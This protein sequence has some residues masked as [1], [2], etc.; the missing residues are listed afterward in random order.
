[1]IGPS[2]LKVRHTVLERRLDL[3]DEDAPFVP[4]WDADYD[5][6]GDLLELLAACVANDQPVLL[7][8]PTGCG[9]STAIRNLAA[10][11][12]QPMI[13]ATMNGQ[14]RESHLF[15]KH[16]AAPDPDSGEAVTLWRDG[17]VPT[18]LRRGW[19]LQLDEFDATP[20][21]V[22]IGLNGVLE[23][24]RRVV[25]LDNE[26][27]VVQGDRHVRIFATANTL[28][29]GDDSGL[30]AGTTVLNEATLDRF[31]VVPVDYPTPAQEGANLIARFR[32][33]AAIARQMADV[34]ALARAEYARS[35]TS[36]TL[37]TRRVIAWARMAV[38]LSPPGAGVVVAALGR[39]F[40]V[41][42]TNKLDADT[43]TL[44]ASLY[45][46]VTGYDLN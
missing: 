16:V 35:T 26:A 37:S 42:V 13:G 24:S 11:L 5:F 44:F 9:K 25:L 27:E 33:D 41:A 10:A 29:R 7:V 2:H 20:A 43:A 28:G 38:A 45:K 15:G 34:A 23:P 32:L 18:A 8:G 14:V 39:A 19:W 1:M 17:I 40:R 36:A 21:H 12:N 6:T 30:Y 3:P 22:A 31:A 4:A 46:R